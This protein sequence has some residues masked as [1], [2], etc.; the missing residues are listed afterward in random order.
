MASQDSTPD[1][2]VKSLLPTPTTKPTPEV[3]P[4]ADVLLFMDPTGCGARAASESICGLLNSQGLPAAHLDTDAFNGLAEEQV[5][6]LGVERSMITISA[7]AL[8]ILNGFIPVISSSNDEP[9]SKLVEEIKF[10]LG[11]NIRIHYCVNTNTPSGVSELISALQPPTVLKSVNVKLV[12]CVAIVQE[13]GGRHFTALFSPRNL[14]ITTKEINTFNSI[15]PSPSTPIPGKLVTATSEDGKSQI[16]FAVPIDPRAIP[17]TE[18]LAQY[19]DGSA[20]ITINS[21]K[22]M[23]SMMRTAASALRAGQTTVTL[24]NKKN[25]KDEPPVSTTYN[26]AE[27]TS[28]P[29][30][31]TICGISFK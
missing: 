4:L 23:P 9:I 16:V 18:K 31:F 29:T 13:F 6:Q 10:I 21:G 8:L 5:Q 25:T 14:S 1:A 15:M 22:H 20:H 12:Y 3:L 26:L 19:A 11:V 28:T 7:V 2:E 17:S 30:T 24:E 27:A